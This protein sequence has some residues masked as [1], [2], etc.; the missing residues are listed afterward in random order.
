MLGSLSV[1]C[2]RHGWW[3]YLQTTWHQVCLQASMNAVIA[4]SISVIP[5]LQ[6]AAYMPK[7]L[8]CAVCGWL[9]IAYDSLA[10]HRCLVWQRFPLFIFLIAFC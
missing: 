5:D 2:L 1:V 3:G 10:I 7:S 8:S 4:V 6:V 9:L